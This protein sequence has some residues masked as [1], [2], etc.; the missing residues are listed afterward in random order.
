MFGKIPHTVIR[1]LPASPQMYYT[2]WCLHFL[3]FGRLSE[4]ASNS[5]Y[6]SCSYI[7]RSS[8]TESALEVLTIKTSSSRPQYLPYEPKSVVKVSIALLAGVLMLVLDKDFPFSALITE[9][10]SSLNS[11]FKFDTEKC[12][13]LNGHLPASL[14]ICGIN[15][16]E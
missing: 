13:A 12:K 11:L 16:V 7:I 5:S 10:F 3:L 6:S 2:P 14:Q 9:S 8:E 15:Q 1:P 4:H